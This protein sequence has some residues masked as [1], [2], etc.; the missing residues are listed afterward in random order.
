MYEEKWFY[1]RCSSCK[2]FSTHS[3][4]DW[5][6][7]WWVRVKRI[8]RVLTLEAS[9][10]EWPVESVFGVVPL[11]LLDQCGLEKPRDCARVC[12]SAGRC[13]FLCHPLQISPSKITFPLHF[14]SKIC[15]DRV[16]RRVRLS[17]KI[18]LEYRDVRIL[19]SG[20]SVQA[21]ERFFFLCKGPQWTRELDSFI[22][23][24]LRS[25]CESVPCWWVLL[26]STCFR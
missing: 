23:R 14:L 8:N 19:K 12:H 1:M 17:W 10:Q 16:S 11:V 4:L 25:T 6:T 2:L 24:C 21:P 15:Q 5:D 22:G 3:G 13:T 26:L 18:Y 7:E 9:L 20:V